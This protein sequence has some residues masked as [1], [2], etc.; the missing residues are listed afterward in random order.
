MCSIFSFVL[1]F[2]LFAGC[3]TDNPTTDNQ[4]TEKSKKIGNVVVTLNDVEITQYAKNNHRIIAYFSAENKGNKA[5]TVS[6]N[7]KLIDYAGVE[8]LGGAVSFQRMYPGETAVSDDEY[9][10]TNIKEYDA[11]FQKP[12][13]ISGFFM[14][15]QRNMNTVNWIVN[16]NEYK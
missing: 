11:L 10:T 14:D 13:T 15:T 9:I 8:H 7:T 12:A 1:V 4:N 16:L 2:S 6:G 3:I 5:I